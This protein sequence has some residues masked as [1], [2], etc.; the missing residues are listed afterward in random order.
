MDRGQR[1]LDSWQDCVFGL[2]FWFNAG[3]GIAAVAV[4]LLWAVGLI[5]L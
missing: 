4:L 3:T 2:V 5:N 1:E